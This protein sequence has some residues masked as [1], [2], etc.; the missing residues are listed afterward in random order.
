VKKITWQGYGSLISKGVQNE[1]PDLKTRKKEILQN[2]IFTR[3]V[4]LLYGFVIH[5]P[6]QKSQ[7]N[8]RRNKVFCFINSS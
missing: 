2:A 8:S 5:P 3:G 7:A 4:T 1:A 6:S